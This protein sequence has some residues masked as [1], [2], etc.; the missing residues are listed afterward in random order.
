MCCGKTQ[1]AD[2]SAIVLVGLRAGGRLGGYGFAELP[3][4][5]VTPAA[6]V[7]R[8]DWVVFPRCGLIYTPVGH[9][10]GYFSA[11]RGVALSSYSIY[12]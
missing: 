11:R 9:A 7:Y 12:S 3:H 2:G 8:A 1:E 10:S 5:I 4:I 6:C